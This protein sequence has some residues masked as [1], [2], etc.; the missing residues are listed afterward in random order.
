[1]R[2]MKLQLKRPTGVLQTSLQRSVDLV[3]FGFHAANVTEPVELK[4]PGVFGHVVPAQNAALGID[5]ARTEFRSWVLANGLRDCVEAVGP[6]LE[7][8][9]KFCLIWTREGSVVPAEDGRFRLSARLSGAEWNMHVVRGAVK[10]DRLPLPEKLRHLETQYSWQRPELSEDILSLNGARNCFAHRQGVVGPADVRNA[11]DGALSIRWRKLKLAIET[12][13][14]ERIVGRGSRVETG[15]LL[16]VS[17][18]EAGLK[19]PVGERIVITAEDYVDISQTFL[20]FGLQLEK[21]I[22]DVQNRRLPQMSSSSSEPRGG[23]GSASA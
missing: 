8:V 13:G 12:E 4:I 2:S 11:S 10:F 3:S 22:M 5:A 23:G 15:E 16:A 7:W 21:S 19:V 9:R 1:M 20:L 17:F 18:V 14:T 6:T